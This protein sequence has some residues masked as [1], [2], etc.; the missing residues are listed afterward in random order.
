MGKN[1]LKKDIQKA[2]KY[3]E[4]YEFVQNLKEKENTKLE[5]HERIKARL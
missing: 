4:S 1:I 3:S 2:L 5:K